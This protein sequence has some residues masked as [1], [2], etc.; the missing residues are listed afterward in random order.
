MTM[1]KYSKYPLPTLLFMLAA[2]LASVSCTDDDIAK[3]QTND[4]QNGVSFSVTDV[5]DAPDADLP[6]RATDAETYLTH[7]IDFNEAGTSDMCLQESTVPGVNP[8]KRTPQTRAWL[9]N[10]IDANFGAFACK[11][12]SAGPDY[13]YNEEVNRHGQMLHPKSWNSTASTLKFYAVYPYM[14]GTNAS[15][16]L[17]QATTGSL[18]YVAFEASTDIAN[19][20]DLMT[21]E[22]ATLNHTSP[23]RAPHVVPLKF[24]HALTAIRFGIGSNLS[25]NK[26]IK[27]IEFQGIYKAGHFDLA[28]KAWSNQSGAQTFKLDNLN[29]ST[30]GTLNTVI[31]KDGNTFLMVPQTLPSGAKIVITFADNTHVTANIGGKIWKAGTT[32]TY[33]MTE[34]NSNWE[35]KI[36][37]TDPA[38]IAYDQTTSTTPYTIKSYRQAPGGIEQ[39]PVKWKVVSYQ[40]STDGGLNFGPETQTKPTWLTNLTTESGDGGTAAESGTATVKIDVTDLLV[41]YNAV[42]QT[43]TPKG[44]AGNYH[45]L[46][47]HD[48]KG[49]TTSRNTANSYLISAPGYYKIPLVYGNA[50]TNGTPNTHAYISQ[51]P[52]GTPNEQFVLRTFKDHNEAD[53]T[54][55][56]INVQNSAAPA[57]QAAIVWTDQSG[58]VEASSLGI[59][60]SGTNAFVHFHV[61][62]DK[63]KNGNAVIAVKN[64]SGTIMWSWH[65]WFDHKEVLE[66][67]KCTNY[68]GV[69]YNFTKQT[70]GFAYRKWEGTTYDKPRVA[71]VKV[72]QTIA[73]HG[74]KQFAYIDIKQNP[75]SVK[76]ISSTFYQFGR[77]DA[78]P[79]VQTVSDGSF[80]EN[81]GNNMSIRNGIQHPEAFYDWGDSW[82]NNP[83][84]GYSYYNLWSM[85]NTTTGRND[86]AVVKTIYDPCPAGF[87]MPASNAF[88][89]FTTTGNGTRN[90]TEWNVSGD[91]DNGWNFNNKITSPNA[92][93][94][95]PASGYRVNNG[96]NSQG[97]DGYYW[98][99]VPVIPY[100]RIEGCDLFFSQWNVQT[101]G[102]SEYSCGYSVRPVADE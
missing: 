7:S 40:E 67:V 24:Y 51:A 92:T 45:D 86:N 22:T 33:M 11:N 64:A 79:G 29:Q 6:S 14:D 81:G 25:W 62:A 102:D 30:S 83:P 4:G 100:S 27:S 70:L 32:K 8:M 88:T 59:E 36:E 50:I 49:N 57:T 65:L 31:V 91:W 95:F 94:Y 52:T 5:Q 2:G 71:R 13:F 23:G 1:K 28:T 89:G 82:S 12:G 75:N 17:I 60:G 80:T 73:N 44:S 39:Q 66:T 55:P 98:S 99:A 74:A 53:I 21:A 76:E 48:F 3:D 38:V 10:T 19:Q 101:K 9:K 68:Q 58:I 96:C 47:T 20:T 15:Q 93:V 69:D 43:A 78:M 84:A 56:Y 16:K 35:Y 97:N 77:K 85:D 54:S 46:S 18:P 26:T 42:L 41:A 63:I 72:E 61:P 90:Q 87:K 34:K 37:T